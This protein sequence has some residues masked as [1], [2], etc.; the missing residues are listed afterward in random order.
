MKQRAGIAIAVLTCCGLLIGCA[1]APEPEP[2]TQTTEILDESS[3]VQLASLDAEEGGLERVS[4]YEVG[5]EQLAERCDQTPDQVGSLIT[6]AV[7]LLIERGGKQT[8]LWL[9][10]EMVAEIPANEVL[11]DQSCEVL[12]GIIVLA[13]VQ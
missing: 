2:T 7:A 13:E 1:Q 8:H 9:L 3:A 5:L 11:D 6:D 12:A 4:D 10:Q